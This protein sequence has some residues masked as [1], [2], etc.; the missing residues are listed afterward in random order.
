MPDAAEAARRVVQVLPELRS[1]P[2]GDFIDIRELLDP[3]AYA[4]LYAR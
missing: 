2:S 4:R 1:R 3:E